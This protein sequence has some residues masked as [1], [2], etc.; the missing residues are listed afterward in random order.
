[1]G[2]P[3]SSS[4]QYTQFPTYRRS[5]TA[6]PSLTHSLTDSNYCR[7]N[8]QEHHA[9][10]SPSKRKPNL[11]HP[12][13]LQRTPLKPCL[14]PQSPTPSSISRQ[15]KIKDSESRLRKNLSDLESRLDVFSRTSIQPSSSLS[16][17][18]LAHPTRKSSAGAENRR[19]EEPMHRVDNEILSIF[20]NNNGGYLDDSDE[21]DEEPDSPALHNPR[22]SF[23]RPSLSP[24][25]RNTN[26]QVTDSQNISSHKVRLIQKTV[27]RQGI[28]RRS[29]SLN[30][31]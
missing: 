28:S 20:L 19:P 2:Q 30:V 22:F 11:L 18:L 31:N 24:L 26:K 23:S 15:S 12:S 14:S 17:Q 10:Q 6:R 27:A 3:I 8:Q 7:S 29:L 1:M 4:V 16:S 13:N 9:F 5:F 25:A 21:S